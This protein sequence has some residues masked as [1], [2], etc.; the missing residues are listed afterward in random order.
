MKGIKLLILVVIVLSLFQFNLYSLITS[1]VEGVVKDKETN[2]LL[3]DVVVGLFVYKGVVSFATAKTKTDENGYFVFNDLRKG[4]YFVGCFKEGYASFSPS[5][6]ASEINPKKHL[7][8]FYLKEGQ[9]KYFE[10]EM[11][12]GGKL[13]IIINKKDENGI[14]GF[15]GIEFLVSK[16]S[17]RDDS[18]TKFFWNQVCQVET[19]ENGIIIVDGLFPGEVYSVSARSIKVDGFPG[20]SKEALIKKNETV[21]IT[22][23][24]D[25]TDKTGIYGNITFSN[26]PLIYSGIVLVNL[27]KNKSITDLDIT[28]KSEYFFRNLEPGSYKLYIY[29]TYENE[30]GKRREI[31]ALVEKDKTTIVNLNL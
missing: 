14:S 8:L 29:F 20:F 30:K 28:H 15:K 18:R 13:K 9:I 6:L 24:Y 4:E 23:L 2:L 25:Y 7:S 11:G 26:K 1:R 12:K 3:K 19:D 27:T 21:E 5:Y 31:S 17:Y 16:K 10:I 22:H